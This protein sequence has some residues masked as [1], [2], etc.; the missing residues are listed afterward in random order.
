MLATASLCMLV[1]HDSRLDGGTQCHAV[2]PVLPI[3][4][5]QSHEDL[6]T[7]GRCGWNRLEIV[8]G[9]IEVCR[10]ERRG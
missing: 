3:K 5:E 7:D 9:C 4:H 10:G 6:V 1:Y 2:H 8:G